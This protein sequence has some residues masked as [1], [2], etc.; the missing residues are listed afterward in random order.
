MRI[1]RRSILHRVLRGLAFGALVPCGARLNEHL[2]AV[3]IV[4]T[5]LDTFLL[6]LLL[7]SSKD[8]WR[9]GPK[10]R[11]SRWCRPLIGALGCT[12]CRNS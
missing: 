4:R 5:L 9:I 8:T 3:S 6:R 11:A 2:A 10:T 1:S 12:A 7:D